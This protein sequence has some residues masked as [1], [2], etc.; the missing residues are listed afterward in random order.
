MTLTSHCV[1]RAS[2]PISV[3]LPTPAGAKMPIRCP[4]P[5]VISPSITLTPVGSGRSII[6]RSIGVGGSA[7]TGRDSVV[8]TG[9][10]PSIGRPRLSITRPSSASPTGTDKT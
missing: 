10:L 2:M 3:D 5:S 4:S 6:S 1:P 8:R 7:N 9:P